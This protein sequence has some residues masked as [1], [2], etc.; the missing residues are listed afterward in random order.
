MDAREEEAVR[1]TVIQRA[2]CLAFSTTQDKNLFI[3][4][5][6][7]YFSAA[8]SPSEAWKM[9]NGIEPHRR[10]LPLSVYQKWTKDGSKGQ[11]IMISDMQ[12]NQWKDLLQDSAHNRV[13]ILPI[14]H[15]SDQRNLSI[16]S[17][18]AEVPSH[19]LGWSSAFMCRSEIT[20]QTQ[21]SP[22]N[23]SGSSVE[24]RIHRT[25]ARRVQLLSLDFIPGHSGHAQLRLTDRSGV[26]IITF[27]SHGIRPNTQCPHLRQRT[28]RDGLAQNLSEN[29]F[30]CVF[31][32]DRTEDAATSADL[33]VLAD[34]TPGSAMMERVEQWAQSGTDMVIWPSKT[35]AY[36]RFLAAAQIGRTDRI[37]AIQRRPDR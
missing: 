7:G 15:S 36:P 4:D 29:E 37:Q 19:I 5:A 18:W 23:P 9:L 28:G 17:V 6:A 30:D 34:W 10:S 16:D 11:L 1:G 32:K 25:G 2:Q 31:L 27:T 26:S 12:R 20:H 3:S 14:E 24:N 22:L 13:K 33:I 21:A 35:G 8:R